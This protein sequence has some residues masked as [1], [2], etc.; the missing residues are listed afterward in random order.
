MYYL[1]KSAIILL[2][3]FISACQTTPPSQSNETSVHQSEATAESV[4]TSYYGEQNYSDEGN[5][6][7]YLLNG[8]R[9]GRGFYSYP[10]GSSYDGEWIKGKK[11]GYGVSK[12]ARGQEYRGFWKNGQRHGKG[13][14]VFADGGVHKGYWIE[15]RAVPDP[16]MV[17]FLLRATYFL[18]Q[19]L[20]IINT[21]EFKSNLSRLLDNPHDTQ[22]QTYFGI[23]DVPE[24]TKELTSLKKYLTNNGNITVKQYINA[25]NFSEQFKAS[26]DYL[27]AQVFPELQT[28]IPNWKQWC[29]DSKR[30]ARHKVDKFMGSTE[31]V[32]QNLDFIEKD[33][34]FIPAGNNQIS[35]C[36]SGSCLVKQGS[37]K[38]C[39]GGTVYSFPRK[40]SVEATALSLIDGIIKLNPN[41]PCITQNNCQADYS[42]NKLKEIYQRR[43]VTGS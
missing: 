7:G 21:K 31:M 20:D 27:K 43:L 3:I 5:Y 34:Q 32:L 24:I 23:D 9:H 38:H 6:K 1:K 33:I 8:K 12:T 42:Y 30:L 15:D 17:K 25:P 11:H 26:I 14:L 28:K 4:S 22:A 37:I 10:N 18:E 19:G 29:E 39:N 13:T 35:L 36:Y 16:G 40:S 2:F 41:S